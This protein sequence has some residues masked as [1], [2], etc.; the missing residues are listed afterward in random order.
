L[1]LG[2]YDE[3]SRKKAYSEIQK[4]LA[5]DVPDLDLFYFRFLQPTNPA[6]KNFAPN[7]MNE[8]WNAFLWEL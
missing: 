7:P 6:F 5:R 3:D 4:L 2:S 8:A 1:A